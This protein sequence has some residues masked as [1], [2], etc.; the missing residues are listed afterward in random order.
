MCGWC[1][2]MNMDVHAHVG[3]VGLWDGGCGDFA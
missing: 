3:S 1:T 2:Y